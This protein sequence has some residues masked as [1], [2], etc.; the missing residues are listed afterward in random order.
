MYV[1]DPGKVIQKQWWG[2][3]ENPATLPAQMVD[4]PGRTETLVIDGDAEVD[5]V[6]A[7]KEKLAFLDNLLGYESYFFASV[8]DQLS[9]NTTPDP[10]A[11]PVEERDVRRK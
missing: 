11:R 10:P 3:T 7:K 6:G 1:I 4:V 2:N 9:Y 8:G 5:L